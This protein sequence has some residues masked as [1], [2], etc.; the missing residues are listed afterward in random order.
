VGFVTL[1]PTGQSRDPAILSE[2]LFVVDLAE[3]LANIGVL[4]SRGPH[5]TFA[6]RGL[7]FFSSD[8]VTDCFS[9]VSLTDLWIAQ[10]Q[11]GHFQSY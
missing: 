4:Y 1:P 11:A 6:R 7:L 5:M 10:D 2:P 3:A 9:L 8:A